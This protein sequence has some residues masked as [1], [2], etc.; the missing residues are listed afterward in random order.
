MPD[1]DEVPIML[2]FGHYFSLYV[3][4]LFD[5]WDCLF[6]DLKPRFHTSRFRASESSEEDVISP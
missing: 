5:L 3:E 4:C 6:Q 2:L 1:R